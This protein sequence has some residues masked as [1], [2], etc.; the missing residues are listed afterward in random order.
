[1]PTTP[2]V[3]IVD[4]TLAGRE[5]LR[6]LLGPANYRL[7]FAMNGPEALATAAD[8]APDLILLDVMMPGMDGFEVC[9]RLRADHRLAE[10]P[11]IMVTALDDRDSRLQGLDA[12]ADDFVS[13]PF[14]R[15]ELRARVR[16]VTRLNRYRKLLSERASFE[17][18]VEQA[19]E[20]YL[21]VDGEDN[22]LYA[23]E[24]ARLYL[25]LAEPDTLAGQFMPL[26]RQIYQCE[27]D[28]AWAGWP[29]QSALELLR[30]RY[31]VRPES[32]VAHSQWLAVSLLNLPSDGQARRL[33]RLH[34]VTAQM[35][36][37]RE[38]W[39]FH[40]MIAHKLRTPLMSLTAGIDLLANNSTQLNA[41]EIATATQS[42][43]QG[44]HRLTEAIG[45]IIRFVEAP[46]LARLNQGFTLTQLTA[47]VE[48]IRSDLQLPEVSIDVD[49]ALADAT[50]VLSTNA[51]ELIVRE[52]LEN[53][54]KFHPAQQPQVT[55]NAQRLDA[56]RAVVRVVDDGRTLPAEE[57]ARAWT[58][59]FQGEKY[60]TGQ[61]AG[62]GLGLAMVAALIWDAGGACR[63]FN[64]SD[65]PGIVV[66]LILPLS[67]D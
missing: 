12:G 27:P 51:V 66:E 61:L 4:D 49:A 54:R 14:D 59:Y 44:V 36:T 63:L 62:M 40:S 25:N 23:N 34:D 52:L 31:L 17:W 10:V 6:A 29:Q 41:A 2:T 65:Q 30:L 57:L 46:A 3:L 43:N 53:A 28:A 8:L 21:I 19:E 47:L 35:T 16:S 48:V 22:L 13:K 26:A 39:T 56:R 50:T 9:R 55:I 11:I 67:D 20:G 33:I 45:D 37:R 64:R 15:A 32:P 5:T 18:V 1:M 38:M 7:E 24:Q 42:A 60:F 58:P